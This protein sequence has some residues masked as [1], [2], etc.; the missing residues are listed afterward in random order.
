MTQEDS[1]II[2]S[3][4]GKIIINFDSEKE[5]NIIYKSI[6]PEIQTSPYYRSKAEI[7]IENQSLIILIKSEDMTSFRASTNSIIK[8]IKLSHSIIKITEQH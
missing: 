7:K 2:N 4:K 5:L 1:D 6:Y 3:V 8:W